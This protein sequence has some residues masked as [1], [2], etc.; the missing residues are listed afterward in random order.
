MNIVG[1][2]DSLGGTGWRS[3]VSAEIGCT[4]GL[5]VQGG[6]LISGAAGSATAMCNDTRALAFGVNSGRIL[7][8][9]GGTNDWAQS[10]ALGTPTSVDQTTF[11][12]ALNVLLAKWKNKHVDS[13]IILVTTNYGNMP[14]RVPGTWSDPEVNSQGLRTQ[15]YADAIRNRANYWGCV[16][17]DCA[18]DC[19]IDN[20]NK[21]NYI[22]ND[23]NYLHHNA[24][25]IIRVARVIADA[26][27]TVIE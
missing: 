16:I 17:A 19:G 10:V 26:I 14:A 11:Y 8:L 24:N 9:M 22:T 21:A 18:R 7:L 27:R 15:D 20:G 6:T 4:F 5:D 23:G 2:T 3:L 12:G 25:G 1:C 13:R